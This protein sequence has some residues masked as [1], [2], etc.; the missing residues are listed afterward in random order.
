[1][2]A[3]N[4][5]WALNTTAGT[6][7]DVVSSELS[8]SDDTP[9]GNVQ[10]VGIA[11]LD[12]SQPLAIELDFTYAPVDDGGFSIEVSL[13]PTT[14]VTT[15]LLCGVAIS[16]GGVAANQMHYHYRLPGGGIVNSGNFAFTAAGT[17]TL[18]V[19]WDGANIIFSVDGSSI[20]SNAN[21]AVPTISS[22]LLNI[23]T[24]QGVGTTDGRSV[25]AVRV[26][27]PLA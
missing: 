17:H 9:R 25:Q 10:S 2:L 8:D 18:R 6:D 7:W 24:S 14:A 3:G 21:T 27:Q 20:L 1:M 12:L 23:G 13:G 5:N 11:A 16:A 4:G 22:L 19:E 15:K 26:Y